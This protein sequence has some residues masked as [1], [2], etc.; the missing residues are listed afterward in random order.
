V[1]L[2]TI[3]A[4]DHHFKCAPVYSSAVSHPLVLGLFPSPDQAA[5]AARALHA[6]GVDRENLSVVAKSHAEAAALARELDGTPGVEIED[7]RPAALL[8]EIGAVFVAAAA[9]GMPGV[10]QFVTAGPLAA[11]LGEAAGHLAGGIATIL[12]KASFDPQTA[13]AWQRSVEAGFVI[14][15][16]H[17]AEAQ[18]VRIE[19]T[20]RENGAEAVG[21][22]RWEGSLL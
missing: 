13:A 3:A 7:S 22:A 2:V 21:L 19:R 17:V 14:L 6:E 9:V 5:V 18:A 16:A 10:A 15:G 12:T 4:H 1:A 8:A 20:L 11:E